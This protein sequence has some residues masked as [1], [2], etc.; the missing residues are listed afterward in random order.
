MRLRPLINFL[1]V[2]GVLVHAGALVRHNT[3]MVGATLDYNA[4]LSDV[5]SICHGNHNSP[6]SV[7]TELPDIPPPSTTYDA[8]AICLGLIAA[9]ALFAAQT[10]GIPAAIEV[11]DATFSV[12]ETT[13]E[14][15]R[16]LHPLPRG[17]PLA[18]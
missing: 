2:L 6:G 4:L 15:P 5:R 9:V 11:K 7:G 18:A 16:A 13:P 14:M 17:P 1:A 10:V 3:A 12:L 8:C